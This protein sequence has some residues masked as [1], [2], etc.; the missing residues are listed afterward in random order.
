MVS[1]TFRRPSFTHV[2]LPGVGVMP[3]WKAESTTKAVALRHPSPM[4]LLP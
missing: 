4:T 2:K 3:N 1:P